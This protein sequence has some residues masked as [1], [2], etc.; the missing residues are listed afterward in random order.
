[1]NYLKLYITDNDPVSI[2]VKIIQYI[3]INENLLKG[4]VFTEDH[5]ALNT[6]SETMKY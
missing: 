6:M 5:S 3:I 2:V 1:M 4:Q